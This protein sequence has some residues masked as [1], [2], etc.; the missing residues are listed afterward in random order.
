[1]AVLLA[2]ILFPAFSI[3]DWFTHRDDFLALSTIRF[4][5]TF[6]YLFLFL[7]EKKGFLPGGPF[8]ASL[9]VLL[10]A[11]LSITSLCL[12]LD[13]YKS[14]YYAGINLVVLAAVLLFPWGARKMSVTVGAILIIYFAGVLARAGFV[15]D[16][17]DLLVNNMGFLLAT[18]IIGVTSAWLSD[19][20]RRESF[21]RLREN[22]ELENKQV[23]LKELSSELA[24]RNRQLQRAI[25]VANAAKEEVQKGLQVREEFISV[26]SHELKTPLTS[27]KLQLELLRRKDSS[28]QL[29]LRMGSQVERPSGLVNDML[30]LS[31]IGA[32]KLG[33]EK[34]PT[35]LGGI[36]D[37]VLARFRE[38]LETRKITLNVEKGD[39]VFGEWDRGRIDQVITNL[40]SNAIK[41]GDGKP[42]KIKLLRRSS[43]AGGEIHVESVP[44][45]GATFTVELPYAG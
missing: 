7:T 19:R 20:L 5:T 44:G 31:R 36:V 6:I 43:K 40:L 18:G 26:A 37:E 11:S 9:V 16:R 3:L 38:Q 35:E 4:S 30:D 28:P 24:L 21:G 39:P 22:D 12:I 23:E 41:Y 8:S 29:V 17:P 45:A 10:L 34:V 1:V 27:L 42:I 14:P 33:L 32:G 13:G 15:I 25:T 2:L